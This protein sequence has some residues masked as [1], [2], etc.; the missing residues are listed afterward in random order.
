MR[1]LLV[2]DDK[3]LSSL[4][5]E[6]LRSDGYALD[7]CFRGDEAEELL[8][9]ENYDLVILDINLPGLD[10]LSLLRHLREGGNDTKVLI[11][12]AKSQ[13]T[14][15]VRGLDLGA[16]DYLAK[17][18]HIEELEA[19]IRNLV[20]RQFLQ[21]DLVLKSQSLCFNTKTREAY[22]GKTLLT[23]TK[24]EQGILEYLLLNKGRPIS[25]EELIEHVWDAQAD[26][27][28]NAV[29]VHIS[30]L[31]KKLKCALGFDPIINRVGIGYFIE[32]K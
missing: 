4:L 32:D 3:K 1:L 11:L 22:A 21:N 31:R 8:S 19:R 10:G 15:K 24:K 9:Y 30:S 2:E 13:I 29:R 12:S 7:Q 23:L 18:F 5:T 17:P 27:I 6:C 14:D 16:N 28:S 26:S 25:Q 20:R